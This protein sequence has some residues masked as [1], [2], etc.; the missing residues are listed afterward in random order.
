MAY[1]RRKRTS[2]RASPYR[3]A[4]RGRRTYAKT[5]KR[6]APRRRAPA[7]AKGRRASSPR[8]IRIVIEQPNTSAVS[9]P[10]QLVPKI[11]APKK[12]KF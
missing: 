1:S 4:V 9:R 3:G 5:T 11:E 12:A 7:K 6:A 10:E 2:R 8:T